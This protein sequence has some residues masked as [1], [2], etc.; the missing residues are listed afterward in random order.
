[1][2]TVLAGGALAVVSSP[3]APPGSSARSGV[4]VAGAS[5]PAP[6]A[7]SYA[8]VDAAGGVTTFGGAAYYGDTIGVPLAKP[9]VGSAADADGGY[10]LVA[11]DG[12][13]FTYG[14]AQFWGSAGGMA[15]NK[16]V[17][18]MAAAPGGSGYWLV[19]SDGGI[20]TYGRTQFYGSTGAI[21]LN[22][23]IVGMASTPDGGGYWLV[24][25][26][27][28][29][30]AFGDAPYYGSTGALHLNKP[31]VGMAAMPGGSGYWLVASDGGIFAFGDA[32]FLG[33]A[34]GIAL[35]QPIV[36]L[37]PT[38]NGGGYWLVAQ[39]AGV[40]T[41][42]DAQFSGSAQSPLHP[43]LY[44][45]PFSVP[46]APV[47]TIM[48][49][50]PGPQATHA[51]GLRVAFAGDSLALY[52]GEYIQNTGPPY[53][54]DDGAA[55]GCGF[56]NGAAMIVWSN[57]GPTYL[58]PGAC[59]YWAEQL[60][61][62]ASRYHP[63]V[64]VIQTG[65]WESQTRLFNGNW[66]TLANPDYAAFIKS[67]LEAAVQIAHSDGGAVVLSTSPYFADG[68]PNNLV[69]Q[70]NQIV[71]DVA[72]EFPFVSIDDLHS[73]LDPGGVYQST[74][75]G[76]VARGADGVHITDAAVDNLIAPALNQIIA[77]VAGAVYGGGS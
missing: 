20:F 64:T 32:P 48:N 4:G 29:I 54:V 37:S 66:E 22:E 67:N 61:W 46:I 7:S 23:P 45:A 44:P 12:G 49:E 35:N 21:R 17:V 63:D 25:S 15:L 14:H 2:A 34:G 55:A 71:E 56:T 50:P 31:V 16:P 11:S 59:S 13:I 36:G 53:A 68:T 42:G 47:V 19:A 38:P 70:Y 73:V 10:W 57:P 26:D 5:A 27:G 51:G 62:L 9:I 43:P 69:D 77:N 18:G 41:Y 3:A 58:N 6:S 75:D 1:M 8:I 72:Q 39:D 65:Y 33:S 30:F 76:I 40:F 52:E 24:A 28:G 60:Q 74:I